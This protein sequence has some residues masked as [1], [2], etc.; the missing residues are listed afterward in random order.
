MSPIFRQGGFGEDSVGN[1]V[2]DTVD[3]SKTG[4]DRLC[5]LGWN[6]LWRPTESSRLAQE[7]IIELFTEFKECE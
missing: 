2:D 6:R 4:S 3:G 1:S 5:S 7:K